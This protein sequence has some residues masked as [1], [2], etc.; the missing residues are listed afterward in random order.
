MI[1]FQI[2]EI[3]TSQNLRFLYFFN[4][5]LCVVIFEN[6]NLDNFKRL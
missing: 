2:A 3:S 5:K 1:L 6:K 4:I